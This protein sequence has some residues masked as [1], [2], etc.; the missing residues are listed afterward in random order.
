M[1]L[2]NIEREIN[3]LTEVLVKTVPSLLEIRLFGSYYNG[4]WNPERS[5]IDIFVLKTDENYSANK[6]RRAGP[7]YTTLES[8]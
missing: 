7:L 2:S 1:D 8:K 3:T 6:Y 4:N 5:D